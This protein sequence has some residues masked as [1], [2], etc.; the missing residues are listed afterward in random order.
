MKKAITRR[1]MAAVSI[2]I[3][4]LDHPE[5]P[6]IVVIVVVQVVRAGHKIRAVVRI[7]VRKTINTRDSLSRLLSKAC[8]VE[9][10]KHTAEL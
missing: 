7:G 2:M 10:G 1:M 5:K 6:L 9:L 8:T 3:E 4:A